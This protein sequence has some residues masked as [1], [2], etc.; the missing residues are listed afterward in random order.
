MDRS[1]QLTRRHWLQ[2]GGGLALVAVAAPTAAAW[3]PNGASAAQDDGGTPVPGTPAARTVRVSGMG[4]VQI[5]PDTAIVTVGVDVL[6][7]TLGDAQAE[8]TTQMTAV[9][10]ALKAAGID[11]KDIQTVN[12]SVSILRDYDE[13]GNPAAIKGFQV[14]NQVNVKLRDLD[15]LGD[16]LDTV[17]EAGAN[18]V[19]GIAFLVDD[20][21]RA[22]SQARAHAVDDARQKADELADAA[23][24][25]L[26]QAVAISESEAPPP[27]PE[28]FKS[29]AED[30]AA[31]RAG[32]VPVQVGT[33]EV[34]VT[35]DITFE[36]T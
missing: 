36:M 32:P 24:M 30:S 26:G 17:V 21:S 13:N 1:R 33:T 11:E 15:G 28:V 34:S 12:Y 31:G 35:V 25:T 29:V 22:A 3:T 7:P 18:N 9:I 6:K 19:Y 23:G 10:D 5:E 16:L 14:S 27:S 8:A 20:P 2:R 4:R